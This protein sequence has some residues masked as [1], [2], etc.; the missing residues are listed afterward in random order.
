MAEFKVPFNILNSPPYYD[1]ILWV[2]VHM[3]VVGLLI[4]TIGYSVSDISK[5]KWIAT[6]LFILTAFYVY[7]DFR[8]A[9]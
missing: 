9:D 1:A 3:T 2:Y 6:L 4:L 5:Q 8:S 7:L